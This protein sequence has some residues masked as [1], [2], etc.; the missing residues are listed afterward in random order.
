[1][2]S[3][4]AYSSSFKPS[5]TA[6]IVMAK[7]VTSQYTKQKNPS[8]WS[9][10]SKRRIIPCIRQLTQILVRQLE[11][12]P[13]M[14][15]ISFFLPKFSRKYEWRGLLFSSTSLGV[16]LSMRVGKRGVYVC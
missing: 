10:N 9:S 8:Q 13:F 3:S 16:I 11:Y 7:K 14:V 6:G 2:I 5:V 12:R 4:K 1:M 15:S